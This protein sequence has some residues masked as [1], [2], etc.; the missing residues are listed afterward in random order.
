M[1]YIKVALET[2]VLETHYVSIIRIDAYIDCKL[3]ACMCA[4]ARAMYLNWSV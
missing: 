1:R 4:H 2:K 3:L